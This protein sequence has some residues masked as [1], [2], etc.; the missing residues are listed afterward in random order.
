[1][2]QAKEAL[3]L[4]TVTPL[5]MGAGTAVGVIDQPIQRE[6]HT[7]HP[8][9][10]GSGIKGALRHHLNALWGQDPMLDRL[11]GPL[12]EEGGV[13]HAGAVSF[14]DAQV[15]AFPVRSLRETF[16]YITS[17]TV[18]ARTRRLLALAG[19]DPG[20]PELNASGEKCR[21]TRPDL[22]TDGR[23]ILESYEFEPASSQDTGLYQVSEWLGEQALPA[24]SA[25][26]WFREKLKSDLVLVADDWFDFFVR[27]AVVVEP[28]VRIDDASGT[29]DDG[30]LF[31]SEN[32]PP[33]T[34]FVALA[35]ASPER[36]PESRRGNGTRALEAR[37]VLEHLL[38]RSDGYAGI[39]DSVVQFG[40]D[41][42]TGRGLVVVHGV[43]GAGSPDLSQEV[44]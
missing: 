33:E 13:E 27:H 43:S 31:Y 18:L 17:P 44:T 38:G 25:H 8:V 12:A 2:F 16:V 3:F 23:L 30:G 20:W 42:T 14:T 37:E 40:A 21:L 41:A 22:L 7:G 9:M 35:L 4:Y 39:H 1:M 28:H 10:A 34:L 29:A 26:D 36:A 15:V 5:H 32:V 6:R 24:D 11:F 19:A